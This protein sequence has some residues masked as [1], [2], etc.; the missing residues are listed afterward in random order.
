KNQVVA[1][2]STSS[3]SHPSDQP[4]WGYE[5]TLDSP[6]P[7]DDPWQGYPGG[8]PFPVSLSSSIP[9]PR[10]GTYV[11]IPKDL[12]MPYINQWNLS[13][14]RQVGANWLFAA[15]YLG[16][17][18]IHNLINSE[19]N[20]AVFLGAGSSV[21]NTQQRRTLILQ[22]PTQGQFYGNIVVADD[23]GT[24]NYNALLLSVQNRLS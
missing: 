22:N 8:N 24:R 14:Q 16:S 17:N 23:G 21:A 12:N 13:L 5:V 7:F 6:G 19:V 1:T 18:V 20:P 10:F 4:P 11:T 3:G 15:N 9:F 2:S